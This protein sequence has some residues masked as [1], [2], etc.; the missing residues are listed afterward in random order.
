MNF[1]LRFDQISDLATC[2]IA[3]NSTVVYEGKVLPSYNFSVPGGFLEIYSSDHQVFE[4][5]H[6]SIDGQSL[7]EVLW[8]TAYFTAGTV[9]RLG[10]LCCREPGRIVL[11]VTTPFSEW[12]I[13]EQNKRFKTDPMFAEDFIYYEKACQLLAQIQN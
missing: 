6:V 7:D 3:I 4:L 5:K 10:D 9:V 13:K 2:K 12:F 11:E 1:D 8:G